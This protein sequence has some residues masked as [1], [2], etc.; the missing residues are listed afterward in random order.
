MYGYGDAILEITSSYEEIDYSNFD[1]HVYG[2]L[3]WFDS[4]CFYFSY[5]RNTQF[6][7]GLYYDSDREILT[8]GSC[9]GSLDDGFFVYFSTNNSVSSYESFRSVLIKLG[10]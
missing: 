6:G 5:F 7:G 2:G 9:Y 8:R 1:G 10:N 3:D 4:P